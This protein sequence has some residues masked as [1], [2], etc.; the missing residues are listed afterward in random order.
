MSQVFVLRS[1]ST[2]YC[3]TTFNQ[4]LFL[5]QALQAVRP[6]LSEVLLLTEV[7][8]RRSG[9]NLSLMSPLLSAVVTNIKQQVSQCVLE[10]LIEVQSENF[11]RIHSDAKASFRLGAYY[12]RAEVTL[13]FVS[14]P[15]FRSRP[16]AKKP[17]RMRCRW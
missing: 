4:T 9:A 7:W 5:F 17:A 10:S 12:L 1:P 11:D 16:R 2:Q 8:K 3:T 15:G 13:R 6:A 14:V